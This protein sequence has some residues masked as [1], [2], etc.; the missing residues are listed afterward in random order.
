MNS[1]LR[2]ITI[3]MPMPGMLPP[4]NRPGLPDFPPGIDPPED[5]P[6]QRIEAALRKAAAAQHVDVPPPSYTPNPMRNI[7]DDLPH[8]PGFFGIQ[9]RTRYDPM[10]VEIVLD[11]AMDI[12]A[13][14]LGD[15]AAYDQYRDRFYERTLELN[16]LQSQLELDELEFKSGVWDR[17]LKQASADLEAVNARRKGAVKR[18]RARN[19]RL[20]KDE[21]NSEIEPT[22]IAVAVRAG[23]S[24][25]F[26]SP[27]QQLAKVGEL[28]EPGASTQEAHALVYEKNLES[29]KHSLMRE[30]FNYELE[31]CGELEWRKVMK[32]QVLLAQSNIELEKQIRELR[33][34]RFSTL[35]AY[36]AERTKALT[37][38]DGPH[39]T[40]VQMK[41]I[42]DRFG[43]DMVDLFDR[44]QVVAFGLDLI[45][46][47]KNPL[48]TP[49]ECAEMGLSFL[50]LS[51]AWVRNVVRFLNARATHDRTLTLSYSLR[52]LVGEKLFEET[53]DQAKKDGSTIN[54]SF[55]IPLPTDRELRFPRLRGVS[56]Y[57]LYSGG[58]SYNGVFSLYLDPPS[59]AYMSLEK[60]RVPLFEQRAWPNPELTKDIGNSVGGNDARPWD[61]TPIFTRWGTKEVRK[62]K[63]LTP[64]FV[65]RIAPRYPLRAPEI[66]A[67][68]SLFNV[69]PFNASAPKGTDEARW[70]I[71]IDA[72]TTTG[73][74][75]ASILK[76]LEIDFYLLASPELL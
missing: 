9:D 71:V 34:E 41:A 30:R 35:Q 25:A 8:H 2:K 11:G 74:E 45:Y 44:L 40:L 48:S 15:R 31:R 6:R 56:C 59:Y 39:N 33:M 3:P 37:E 21:F 64:A 13:R 66:F 52:H 69:S 50:D 46:G 23:M 24:G 17:S 4:K 29:T 49:T 27:N 73:T 28:G 47:L 67:T 32:G 55:T 14:A 16:Y 57:S 76:D 61:D 68:D 20:T 38:P 58:D 72:R 18:S 12:L 75:V 22:L 10:H 63:D 42:Q 62:Q 36:Q 43:R 51:V 54:M 7:E 65:S 70:T 5:D 1:D 26:H 60:A 19:E 53:L